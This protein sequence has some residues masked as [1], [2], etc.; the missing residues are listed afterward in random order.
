M[1]R[2]CLAVRRRVSMGQSEFYDVADS[3]DVRWLLRSNAPQQHFWVVAVVRQ[4]QGTSAVAIP[5][6]RRS[7][8]PCGYTVVGRVNQ[9]AVSQCKST[10]LCLEDVRA[11]PQYGQGDPCYSSKA[12]H[13]LLPSGATAEWVQSLVYIAGNCRQFLYRFYNSA[14]ASWETLHNLE[15]DLSLARIASESYISL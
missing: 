6:G 4:H 7:I 1:F 13:L 12:L 3:R 15:G 9:G 2:A 5:R 11:H 8:P 10:R 14:R